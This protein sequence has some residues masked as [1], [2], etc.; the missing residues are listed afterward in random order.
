MPIFGSQSPYIRSYESEQYCVLDTYTSGHLWLKE[1]FCF[2][3]QVILINIRLLQ[4]NKL[5][6]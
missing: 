4:I 2:I 1:G 3:T 6:I 5:F